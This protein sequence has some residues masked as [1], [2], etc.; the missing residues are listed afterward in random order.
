MNRVFHPI[1]IYKGGPCGL[2]NPIFSPFMNH[3]PGGDYE[4][5]HKCV[6]MWGCN[7]LWITPD[8]YKGVSFWRTYKKRAKLICIDPQKASR[9]L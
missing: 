7:P 9:E 6:I 5:G 4:R 8:E 3:L 2:P 1:Q